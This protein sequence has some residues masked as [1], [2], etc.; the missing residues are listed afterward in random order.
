MNIKAIWEEMKSIN[1][2]LG[3]YQN[4]VTAQLTITPFDWSWSI[5]DFIRGGSVM[6]IGPFTYFGMIDDDDES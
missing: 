3:Y 6:S 1:I 5:M 4:K 2:T